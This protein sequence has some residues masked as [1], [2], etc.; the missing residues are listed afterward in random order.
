MPAPLSTMRFWPRFSQM[1]AME[2]KGYFRLA[3]EGQYVLDN[4]V[5]AFRVPRMYANWAITW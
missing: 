4:V 2:R 5:A 1:D 3:K